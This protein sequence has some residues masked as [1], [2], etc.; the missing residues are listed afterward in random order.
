MEFKYK[1]EREVVLDKETV[2]DILTTAIEGGIGYWSIL[3]CDTKS[4]EKA[5]E[6]AKE[7]LKDTPCYCDVAYKLF[8]LGLPIVLEDVEEDEIYKLT[9]EKFIEGCRLYEEQ[10][11]SSILQAMENGDFDANDADCIIQYALFN[12]VVFG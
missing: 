6:L 12:E 1:V 9:K 10:T 8:E 7:E 4:W 2:K 11:N 3:R 5:R